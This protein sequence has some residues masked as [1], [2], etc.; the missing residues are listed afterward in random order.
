MQIRSLR[1]D[2]DRSKFLSGDSDLD[3]FFHNYA[4]QNQFRHHIGTTWV[5]VEKDQIVGYATVAAGHLEADGLPASHRSGLPK[6]PIP[7]LRLARLAA[8]SSERGKGVGI[9]LLRFVFGLAVKLSEEFGCVGIVVDAKPGARDFYE[10]FGFFEIGCVAG[11][12]AARPV[13]VMMFLPL[14]LVRKAM[15]P[16]R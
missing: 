4:G 11:A 10:K 13:P 9:A 16:D 12:G 3:R 1:P 6:H 5:A 7:I 15:T 8:A 2:D 14:D